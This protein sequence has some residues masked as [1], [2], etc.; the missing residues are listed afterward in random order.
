MVRINK[1]REVGEKSS[2]YY[3]TLGREETLA[4]SETGNGGYTATRCCRLS[5]Q[6]ADRHECGHK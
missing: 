3:P 4:Q 2:K 6:S 1:R 5:R